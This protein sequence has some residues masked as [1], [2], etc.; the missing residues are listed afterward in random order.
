MTVLQMKRYFLN[1]KERETYENT[2][3]KRQ[4][5]LLERILEMDDE[6]LLERLK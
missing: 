5:E 6:E 4:P 3:L 2:L 1:E